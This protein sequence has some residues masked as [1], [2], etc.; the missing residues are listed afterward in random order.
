M[1]R[2]IAKEK[3]Q[4]TEIVAFKVEADL[5]DFLNKLQN[6]SAFIRKAIIAQLGMACPLCEGSG[7]VP[8]GL[9]NHYSPVIAKN[10]TRRCDKCGAKVTLPRNTSDVAESDRARLEQFLKGGEL[11]C[12]DCYRSVPPCDDCGWHISPENVA[13]H[14]RKVH[15]D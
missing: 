5:A 14:F 1:T 8:R 13:D 4:K 12:A 9:H 3:A 11:F 15:I 2:K 10:N 7:T 6:K